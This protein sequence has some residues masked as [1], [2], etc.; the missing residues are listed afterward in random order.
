MPRKFRVWEQKK[1]WICFCS[2]FCVEEEEVDERRD[3]IFLQN[4]VS[5]QKT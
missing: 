5:A 4:A 3:G 1:P 2:M